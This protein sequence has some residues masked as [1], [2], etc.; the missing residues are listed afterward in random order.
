MAPA[1]E[2]RRS[3]ADAKEGESLV[4]LLF[5]PTLPADINTSRPLL[6]AKGGSGPRRVVVEDIYDLDHRRGG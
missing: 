5:E 4:D 6:R 3:T 1:E 2:Q